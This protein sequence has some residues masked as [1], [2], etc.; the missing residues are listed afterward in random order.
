MR[1]RSFFGGMNLEVAL[2][3]QDRVNFAMPFARL[4]VSDDKLDLHSPMAGFAHQRRAR[5]VTIER[6]DVKA[7]FPSTMRLHP[8]VGI[9]TNDGKTH[10]FW[11]LHSQTVLDNLTARGYPF[12]T[13]H[14]PLPYRTLLGLGGKPRTGSG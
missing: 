5:S 4:R 11:T 8:G 10:Y 13:E 2:T 9:E 7:V 3:G 6:A 14:L 12:G 1:D